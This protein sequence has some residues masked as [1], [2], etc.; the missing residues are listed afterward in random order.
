MNFKSKNVPESKGFSENTDEKSFKNVIISTKHTNT[1]PVRERY[2]SRDMHIHII[3]GFIQSISL[4][5][6][7]TILA[8][9]T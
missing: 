8:S 4:T 7:F 5:I 2:G 3:Q 1:Q 6:F 9:V